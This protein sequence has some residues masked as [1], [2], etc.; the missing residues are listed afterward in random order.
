MNFSVKILNTMM[1]WKTCFHYQFPFQN[2]K[3]TKEFENAVFILN[4]YFKL[5]NTAT[6]L[7]NSFYYQFQFQNIKRIDVLKNLCSYQ[8]PLQNIKH[9]DAL[10]KLCSLSASSSKYWIYS[11]FWKNWFHSKLPLQSSKQMEEFE[12]VVCILNFHFKILNTTTILKKL[13]LLSISPS[14]Y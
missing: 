1:F 13:F 2:I 14:K 10:K 8:F 4:F 3:Q 9:N 7:K 12:K 11:T 5:L 6:A